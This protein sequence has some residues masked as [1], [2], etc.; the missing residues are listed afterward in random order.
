M[1]TRVVERHNGTRS[2]TASA[3][4]V[5]DLGLF[6]SAALVPVDALALRSGLQR[7]PSAWGLAHPAG[8]A[9]V[10]PPGEMGN[11]RGRHATRLHLKNVCMARG[12]RHER[13]TPAALSA[14]HAGWREPSMWSKY[15]HALRYEQSQAYR[16]HVDPIRIAITVTAPF[17]AACRGGVHGH[18]EASKRHA[19]LQ[20]IGPVTARRNAALPLDVTRDTV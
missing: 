12:V 5:E 7:L 19:S 15:P 6:T 20:A 1:Q 8:R 13:G 17:L 10:L 2:P 16:G 3:Q 11:S 14:P 4:G 18:E 9:R